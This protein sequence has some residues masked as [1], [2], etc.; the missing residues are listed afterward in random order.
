MN[1]GRFAKLRG[2]WR[3][4]KGNTLR[5]PDKT[6]SR[7]AVPA[8]AFAKIAPIEKAIALGQGAPLAERRRSRADVQGAPHRLAGEDASLQGANLCG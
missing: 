4:V 7:T 5:Y 2:H 3:T 6:V 1:S 8:W